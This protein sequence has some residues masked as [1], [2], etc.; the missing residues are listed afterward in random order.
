MFFLCALLIFTQH[1]R[2]DGASREYLVK[3]AFLY[4]FVKFVEWPGDLSVSLQKKLDICVIGNNPFNSAGSIFKEASTPSLALNLTQESSPEAAAS[5][6]HIV[7]ISG[8]ER[9]RVASILQALNGRP[10]LTV[11]DADSFA[12]SGGMIGFVIV[13]NKVKLVVN[14]GAIEAAGMRID[15]Q[16]LEIAMS[17]IR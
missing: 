6:C 2:A 9:G 15:A 1:A 16:L 17:V 13:D 8:S 12:Q 10:V 3:A 5:H 4:N 11:S 7:F 14:R